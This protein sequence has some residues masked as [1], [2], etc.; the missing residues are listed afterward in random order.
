MRKFIAAFVV[1]LGVTIGCVWALS[2]MNMIDLE[3]IVLRRIESIPAL[4]DHTAIYRLG[5]S[6]N[7]A[8]Q[9]VIDSAERERQRLEDERSALES[10]R[11]A[12]ASEWKALDRERDLLELEQQQLEAE[13]RTLNSVREEEENIVQLVE[14][15][16]QMRP[17][18]L[19]RVVEDLHDDFLMKLLLNMEERQAAAL[20][21]A[22]QPE[23]AA[24]ISRYIAGERG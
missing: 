14:L 11:K 8:V 12:L 6:R 19:V 3:Q 2:A 1:V 20:L 7:D 9:E 5:R 21:S 4:A 23:R 18:A 13:W 15:Y 22:L 10:E 16:E 17:E 24:Q